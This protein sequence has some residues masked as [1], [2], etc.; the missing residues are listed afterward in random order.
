MKACILN[1][2]LLLFCAFW[3]NKF[4]FRI[5]HYLWD[6]FSS[7]SCGGFFREYVSVSYK[8][9]ALISLL[10]TLSHLSM[11]SVANTT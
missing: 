8:L 3:P 4:S 6:T 9:S 5:R 1:I 11:R 2:Q 7:G 10:L